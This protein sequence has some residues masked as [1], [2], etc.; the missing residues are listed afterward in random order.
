MPSCIRPMHGALKGFGT[1][2][3]I[4]DAKVKSVAAIDVEP[5]YTHLGS[6]ISFW[7]CNPFVPKGTSPALLFKG[8]QDL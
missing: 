6:K 2:L 7:L 5:V 3:V 4:T 8:S 1:N